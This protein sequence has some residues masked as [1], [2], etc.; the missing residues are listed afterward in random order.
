MDHIQSPHGSHPVTSRIT[1]SHLTDHIQSPHGSHPMCDLVVCLQANG[2]FQAHGMSGGIPP[3]YTLIARTFWHQ[4]CARCLQQ[5]VR[6]CEFSRPGWTFH[7]K[8]LW[9]YLPSYSLPSLT[10]IGSPNFGELC[11]V[12]CCLATGSIKLWV[13][14]VWSVQILRRV[15]LNV[16]LGCF[17]L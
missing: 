11:H 5:R 10:F 2:F 12:T 7:G 1:S 6:L 3:A 9:Y 15:M 8:G 4:V 17:S 13:Q 16:C 14:N